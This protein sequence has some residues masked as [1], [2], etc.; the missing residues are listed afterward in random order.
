[1]LPSFLLFLAALVSTAVF[2]APTRNATDITAVEGIKT[3]AITRPG[4]DKMSITADDDDNTI[5][6][7]WYYVYPGAGC[8]RRGHIFQVGERMESPSGSAVF[9]MHWYGHI[10]VY[11]N[12]M[13]ACIIHKNCYVEVWENWANDIGD[14]YKAYQFEYG[15]NGD[16]YLIGAPTGDGTIT[17]WN[18]GTWGSD[19]LLCIQDDGNLVLYN[20]G[21][22]M[23]NPVWATNTFV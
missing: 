19:G 18:A 23:N 9:E 20:D 10:K 6:E 7:N 8:I 21:W 1:M 5:Q 13:W 12:K 3:K 14:Y 4:Y 22:E 16:L 17:R 15:W 11:H 2:A